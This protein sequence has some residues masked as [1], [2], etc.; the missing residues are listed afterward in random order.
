MTI[1]QVFFEWIRDRPQIKNWVFWKKKSIELIWDGEKQ[2]DF[3]IKFGTN[4]PLPSPLQIL[5][6]TE[7]LR[8]SIRWNCFPK[9]YHTSADSSLAEYSCFIYIF[10]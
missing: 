10:I 6:E 2:G 8:T 3:L 1:F 7:K 4:L 5:L 9:I